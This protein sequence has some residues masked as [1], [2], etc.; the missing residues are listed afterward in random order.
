MANRE[1]SSIM[2]DDK[3]QLG[4]IGSIV[5]LLVLLAC[6]A[7]P[8]YWYLHSFPEGQ[9]LAWYNYLVFVGILIGAIIFAYGVLLVIHIVAAVEHDSQLRQSIK[10]AINQKY[11]K[12]KEEA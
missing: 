11:Q 8:S 2:N 7:G 6:I 3:K 5:M 10:T 12:Q 9:A 1:Q 4:P